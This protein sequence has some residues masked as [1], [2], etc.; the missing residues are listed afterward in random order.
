VGR[1]RATI[2]EETLVEPNNAALNLRSNIEETAAGKRCDA[3]SY[4]YRGECITCPT[5]TWSLYGS[6]SCKGCPA[7]QFT[8][9]HLSCVNCEAGEYSQRKSRACLKCA[10][11]KVSQ[12]KSKSCTACQAGSYADLVLN[13]CTK[14]PIGQYSR[15][16]A[17]ACTL[18]PPG[19]KVNSLQTGCIRT[20]SSTP[21]PTS[22]PTTPPMTFTSEPTAPP[23]TPPIPYPYVCPAGQFNGGRYDAVKCYNC[24]D[25]DTEWPAGAYSCIGCQLSLY[26]LN[27]ARTGCEETGPLRCKPGYFKTYYG[28]GSYIN[29]PCDKCPTG[30][31]RND[32]YQ[33]SY[34]KACDPGSVP[35]AD[36]TD[37]IK[38]TPNPTTTP[39]VAPS[40]TSAPPTFLPTK[41]PTDTPTTFGMTEPPSAAIPYP[42]VCPAGQFNGGYDTVKCY[43]C[44]DY[45]T[46][47]PAGAYSCIGCRPETQRL[48]EDRTSCEQ[49]GPLQCKPGYYKPV[50]GP[51]IYQYPCDRCPTGTYR[52]YG[53]PS[54][55][56]CDSCKQGFVPNANQT[57]CVVDILQ[58][59]TKPTYLFPP[60]F[61]P[62]SPPTFTPT[63]F[64]M[65]VPPSTPP[66]PYPYVCP[67]GEYNSGS[68]YAKRCTSCG[69]GDTEWPAGAFSCIGCEW[70]LYRL[71][72]ARTGCEETGPLRCK[73][74]YYKTWRGPG[75]YT[76]YPCDKCP[77]GTYS[78]GE[79]PYTTY[80]INCKEGFLPNVNQTDCIK[81]TPN[82][83]TTPTVAP[84][85]TSAPPTILPTK[86]PTDT[87]TTFGMT[88][89]PSAAIPYPYVCPA[90][91]YNGGSNYAKR[92]TSCGFG[93]T[94]WP[95]GAYSCIGCEWS[96]YR[97]NEARTGCEET[98]PLNCKPGYYKTWRGPGTDINYPCD[99]CPDGT[100]STGEY[101]YTTFCRDCKEG[102]V[103]N[104]DQSDCVKNTPNPTTTPT[105]APV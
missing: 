58:P 10:V 82:P 99:K 67:A 103:P 19:L 29:Y 4:R 38:D 75:I 63:T 95:A 42:Y 31:Y 1:L 98:G 17:S 104:A 22:S 102:F 62:T 68:N 50:D 13:I 39:T 76:T 80:C 92:C 89:P 64:G 21:L 71:N 3:G 53:S 26:R 28:Q 25:Y 51:G 94:E 88:E 12:P 72:E 48:S 84:T 32:P 34:C 65:T 49:L 60:T 14:C 91:E 105:M 69:F 87:P 73:P 96:L 81:N 47:W 100:Y 24:K 85:P 101:P 20:R 43:N 79:Y 54:T 7:G 56:Y 70:S 45:D 86:V 61:L 33:T 78:T 46:E 30:T 57:R 97:L 55:T 6:T 23:S 18:C 27:E 77:D 52:N 8:N 41:V 59:T 16:K 9:D 35:N 40:P 66:I 11:G 15:A 90:G 83:T 44:K 36:Q 37:C 5:G 2:G 74:G 93:D